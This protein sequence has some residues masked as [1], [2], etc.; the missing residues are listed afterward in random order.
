MYVYKDINFHFHFI[1]FSHT[2]IGHKF[3][4][5]W[6]CCVLYLS[7]WGSIQVCMQQHLDSACMCKINV[8]L[9]YLFTNITMYVCEHEWVYVHMNMWMY[10]FI[11][12]FI[13]FA[14]PMV[15]RIIK[16][17][18]PTLHHIVPNAIGINTRQIN[19]AWDMLKI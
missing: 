16:R 1:F 14:C 7:W 11:Q 10:V 9:L 19:L 18:N 12:I 2:L 5:R 4:G 15:K 13:Y 8:S 6:G 17:T 3:T